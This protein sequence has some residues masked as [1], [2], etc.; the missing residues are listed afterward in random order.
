MTR[1]IKIN[2]NKFLNKKNKK[3]ISTYL[4]IYGMGS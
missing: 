4:F 2:D 1:I 3:K